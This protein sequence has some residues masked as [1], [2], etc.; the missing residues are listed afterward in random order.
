MEKAGTLH[1]ARLPGL[2]FWIGEPEPPNAIFLTESAI[3][4][5]SVLALGKRHQHRLCVVS[6][7]GT[8]TLIPPWLEAWKPERIYCGYDAD[9]AGHQ[10]ADTLARSNHRVI[11]IRPP[12]DGADWNDMILSARS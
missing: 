1:T 3:D 8:A 7:A 6:T 5:L 11:R 9:L 10:V 12:F 2:E 4:A